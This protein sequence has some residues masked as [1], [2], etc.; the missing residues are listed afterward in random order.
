MA[1][2]APV[3][4]P[5]PRLWRMWLLCAV[6][7]VGLFG[8]ACVALPDAIAAFFNLL[9][10]GRTWLPPEFGSAVAPYLSFVYGVLG[11]VMLGWAVLMAMVVEGPFRRARGLADDRPALRGL[12]R[13]RHHLVAGHR[14]LAER[15]AQ[16][17]L[18]AGLRDPAGRDLAALPPALSGRAQARW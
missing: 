12:V 2:P 6:S 3:E 14:L 7:G 10:F 9:V 1:T 4:N 16:R 11:A 17:G 8:L 13:G 15:G 18:R 5:P